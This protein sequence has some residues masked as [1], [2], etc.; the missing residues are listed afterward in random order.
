[1]NGDEFRVAGKQMVDYIADYLENIRERPVL[2]SVEPFYIRQVVPADPPEKPEKWSDVF[3]DIEKVVM[4]G[5]RSDVWNSKFLI[6]WKSYNIRL[7]SSQ[8]NQNTPSD[9]PLAQPIL[10]LLFSDW[11]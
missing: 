2:P 7:I 10:L 5:V 1:M 8:S 3:G 6:W 11:Q 9:D 4:N